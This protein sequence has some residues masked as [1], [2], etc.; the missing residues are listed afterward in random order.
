[1]PVKGFVCG[2]GQNIIMN[3]SQEEKNGKKSDV[4]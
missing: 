4:E 2:G 3:K 1:M